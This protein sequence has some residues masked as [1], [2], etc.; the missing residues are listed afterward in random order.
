MY[1]IQRILAYKFKEKIGRS[2]ILLSVLLIGNLL[3]T[4]CNLSYLMNQQ[5]W[6]KNYALLEGTLA[7]DPS[8]IDGNVNTGGKAEIRSS[9]SYSTMHRTSEVYVLLPQAKLLSKII[10]LSRDLQEGGLKG[11]RCELHTYQGAQWKLIDFFT[12]NGMKTIIKFPAVKTEEVRLRLPTWT[13][14]DSLDKVI[15]KY[16]EEI[17]TRK[18]YDSIP[19]KILEIEVYGPVATQEAYR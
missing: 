19:P 2:L 7:T 9:S 12:I 13:K 8:M 11:K 15:N 10:L 1:E 16:N 17:I 18:N 3:T 4:G 6:S 14:F 5:R